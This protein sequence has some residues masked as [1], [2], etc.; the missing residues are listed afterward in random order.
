MKALNHN[1]LC[2]FNIFDHTDYLVFCSLNKI[3]LSASFRWEHLI[4]QFGGHQ[5]LIEY[6]IIKGNTVYKNDS[7][8]QY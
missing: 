8:L 7:I 4:Y 3:Q 6:V 5:E 1:I 2:L